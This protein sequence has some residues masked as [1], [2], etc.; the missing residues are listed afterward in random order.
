MEPGAY[1]FKNNDVSGTPPHYAGMSAKAT[2]TGGNMILHF[3]A[4]REN[5]ETDTS[6]MILDNSGRL[7]VGG[8]RLLVGTSGKI[9]LTINDWI[10]AT[11]GEKQRHGWNSSDFA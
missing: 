11:S 8:S 9:G 5:Y 3:H 1:L 10:H 2:G 4:A 6:D 7:E